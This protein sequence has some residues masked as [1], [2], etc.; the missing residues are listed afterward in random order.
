[1][2]RMVAARQ[3]RLSD[4][5]R[6][7]GFAQWGVPVFGIVRHDIA[8]AWVPVGIIIGASCDDLLA[9]IETGLRR[10]KTAKLFT[11]AQMECSI[12]SHRTC[13]ISLISSRY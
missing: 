12:A 3:H 6:R 11:E 1:M 9:I 5:P 13:D 7:I 2:D 4:V 8:K 10:H